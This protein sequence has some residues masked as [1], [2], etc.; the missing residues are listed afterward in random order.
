VDEGKVLQALRERVLDGC[1]RQCTLDEGFQ[2]TQRL[3]WPNGNK[4][5]RVGIK[6][7][8][9]EMTDENGNAIPVFDLRRFADAPGACEDMAAIVIARLTA[10]R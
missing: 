5:L 9:F 8:R 7:G 2:V 1:G 4:E 3:C 6:M 10:Q